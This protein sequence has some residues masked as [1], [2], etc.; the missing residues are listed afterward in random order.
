MQ[1]WRPGR[2]LEQAGQT[3]RL[4]RRRRPHHDVAVLIGEGQNFVGK[5]AFHGATM[6]NGTVEGEIQCRGTLTVGPRGLARASISADVVVIHGEVAGNVSARE[7][8]DLTATARM[9]GDIQAPVIVIS[10]GVQFHG[11]CRVTQAKSPDSGPT[12]EGP[13]TGRRK[14]RTEAAVETSS[15]A[16]P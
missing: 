4:W 16:S 9:V 1:P 6:L 13:T 3:V 14:R 5:C 7:R 15:Q 11:N 8:V 12:D 10:E 2:N